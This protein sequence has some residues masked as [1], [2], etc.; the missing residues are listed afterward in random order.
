MPS[1]FDAIFLRGAALLENED[2][3][4]LRA[5]QAAHS[6]CFFVPYAKVQKPQT[7]GMR[8][9]ENLTLM[10][11]VH[12]NKQDGS[13][14][15]R[16]RRRAQEIGQEGCELGVGHFARR[17]EKVGVNDLAEPRYMALTL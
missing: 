2:E 13:R 9:I 11:P 7:K 5:V 15:E 8:S 6:T 17:H 4:V 10:A 3:L 1:E 14:H 16:I 12:E